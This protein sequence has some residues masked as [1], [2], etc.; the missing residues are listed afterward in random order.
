MNELP[1]DPVA[2]PP[3]D[4]R[5]RFQWNKGG[6]FGAQFGV[7]CWLVPFGLLVAPVA[8]TLALVTGGAFVG[9][10]GLGFWLW[11]Q[12][13]KRSAFV[14]IQLMLLGS[15]IANAVVI[16]L[17]Q[18]YED[19]LRDLGR[20]TDVSVEVSTLLILI[21]PALMVL[22]FIQERLSRR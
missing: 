5:S 20:G 2:P 18:N 17:A 13:A 6:W 21:S 14:G 15:T 22:F 3:A 4:R 11:S 7:S 16:L 1:A 19:A 8:G 10:N 9:L 12:R